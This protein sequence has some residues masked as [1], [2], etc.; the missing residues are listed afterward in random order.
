MIRRPPRS[1]LFPYTTL[2]RSGAVGVLAEADRAA[3]GGGRRWRAVGHGGGA[4][5][6][7][8]HRN[9]L[10]RAADH[11]AGVVLDLE[12]NKRAPAAP[13]A[14]VAPRAGRHPVGS[15]RPAG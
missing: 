6:G 9:R 4:A 15:P 1:T 7:A 11:S 10:R 12:K 14:G 3:G 13:G 8:R 5:A 2:F